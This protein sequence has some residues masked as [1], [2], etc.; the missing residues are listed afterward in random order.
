MNRRYGH[1]RILLFVVCLFLVG[2]T[3]PQAS[4]EEFLGVEIEKL[5][6]T[7]VVTRDVNVR[8]K[9]DTNSERIAGLRKGKRVRVVGRFQGWFA[10]LQDGKP[11][12]FVYRKYLRLLID[13][14]L[15]GPVRDSASVNDDGKCAFEIVFTGRSEAGIEEFSMA[16][17][18]VQV[19][20]DRNNAKLS[21]ILF[22]FMTEGAYH[23]AKPNVHQI[24][25]DLLEIND[26][27]EYDESFTTN[28]FYNSDKA[29]VAFGEIT[30]EAYAGKPL[31]AEAGASS[32]SEA[33]KAAVRMALESWNAKAWD[34]LTTALSGE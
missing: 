24:G 32:V 25:I 18:E 19:Q 26:D 11:Y 15:T 28:V 3:V 6:R 9:P 33:L 4:A 30:L 27:G 2:F 31:E 7:Y 22:M 34:D 29:K 21:F 8:A 23:P 5:D 17:Y 12:G 10:I 1:V 13:G 16:D 20:C 14:E